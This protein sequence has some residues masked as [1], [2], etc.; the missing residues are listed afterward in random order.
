M[1]DI[2]LATVPKLPASWNSAW[3]RTMLSRIARRVA[4]VAMTAIRIA[5]SPFRF[6]I[7]YR[8][9]SPKVIDTGLIS[10]ARMTLA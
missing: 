1:D 6:D 7:R 4:E 8:A 2:R 3:V 10:P 9:L 5:P